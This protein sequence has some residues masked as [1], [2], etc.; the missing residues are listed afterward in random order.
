MQVQYWSNN[1]KD[2]TT[3]AESVAEESARSIFNG[4]I[5]SSVFSISARLVC[6]ACKHV[7]PDH[8]ECG[9]PQWVML[10]L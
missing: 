3:A 6:I 1:V 9:K 4:P 8:V 10:P 2:C 5:A 7:Y